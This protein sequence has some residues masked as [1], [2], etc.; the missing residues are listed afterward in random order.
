ME[1]RLSKLTLSMFYE[2]L[3]SKFSVC[4]TVLIQMYKYKFS[5]HLIEL[6]AIVNVPLSVFVEGIETISLPE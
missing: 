1:N 6:S 5:V 4:K 3:P 2:H